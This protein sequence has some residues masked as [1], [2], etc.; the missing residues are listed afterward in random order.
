[1][2][3]LDITKLPP[4]SKRCVFCKRKEAMYLCDYRFGSPGIWF[5]RDYRS[6]VKTN[7][8]LPEF[9]TCDAPMCRE[10][11]DEVSNEMHMCPAH[12]NF[13]TNARHC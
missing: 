5:T 1:M 6:F 13:I 3:R 7:S 9:I 11:V 12:K 8:N 4:V 2:N 10:C